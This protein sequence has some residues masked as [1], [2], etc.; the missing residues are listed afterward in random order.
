MTVTTV[1][2]HPAAES[3]PLAVSGAQLTYQKV[4]ELF[5]SIV[6][7]CRGS[8]CL[9]CNDTGVHCYITTENGQIIVS[10]QGEKA[11][12]QN[13]KELDCAL[14][15][16]LVGANIMQEREFYDFQAIC[17][18][19]VIP[20]VNFASRIFSP[21]N[22]IA[23]FL[24]H[25]FTEF[26]LLWAKTAF[27]HLQSSAVAQASIW[28]DLPQISGGLDDY[29]TLHPEEKQN[30]EN[31]PYAYGSQSRDESDFNFANQLRQDRVDGDPMLPPAFYGD[32]E[33][34][35]LTDTPQEPR[36]MQENS[37]LPTKTKE[38]SKNLKG[39]QSSVPKDTQPAISTPLGE[40][41]SASN[42]ANDFVFPFGSG[43]LGGGYNYEE[44]DDPW[45]MQQQAF[46]ELNACYMNEPT[47]VLGKPAA[48]QSVGQPMP[49]ASTDAEG[50]TVDVGTVFPE[51][52]EIQL[53][54]VPGL[55]NTPVNDTKTEKTVSKPPVV[56]GAL[57]RCIQRVVQMRCH[58]AGHSS[59]IIGRQA[60]EVMCE[61]VR[62][63]MSHFIEFLHD[64]R[65]PLDSCTQRYSVFFLNREAYAAGQVA[66]S[67]HGSKNYGKK[68]PK[69]TE[70]GK[71]L[72][73]EALQLHSKIH[74]GTYC[75]ACGNADWIVSSIP[76]T[77]LLLVVTAMARESA[78]VNCNC[79]CVRRYRYGTLTLR[80]E[81]FPRPQT[82]RAEPPSPATCQM[83]SYK[84]ENASLCASAASQ[85]SSGL[86]LGRLSGLF[87][88]LALFHKG[89]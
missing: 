28:R 6:N 9:R 24:W 34:L 46:S 45:L 75:L 44:P 5:H 15:E 18:E 65:Q 52:E 22:R 77:N 4:T 55:N 48:S 30:P 59:N 86:L 69:K 17:I 11:V 37:K 43:G 39:R 23:Q 64:C 32:Y 67:K 85:L 57:L 16:A 63:R 83:V 38:E 76:D 56:P 12:N 50:T 13:L 33:V 62:Q 40:A 41:A 51:K 72:G 88:F 82:H 10:T 70:R 68:Y 2:S 81:A 3:V 60:C 49:S 71:S 27:F 47:L 78:A 7:S 66:E 87:T 21:L 14:M 79:G 31:A 54:G 42:R 73:R 36:F 8:G 19:A 61:A 84:V 80:G 74:S 20:E 29:S 1:V 89:L 25:F 58:A 35:K 53:R 26:L